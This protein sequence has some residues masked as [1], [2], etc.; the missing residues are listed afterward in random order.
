VGQVTNGLRA[1]LS[2]PR[3]YT[4]FQALMGGDSVRAQFVARNIRPEAGMNVLDI[5]CGP[6]GIL[7]YLPGVNYW[8]FDA[9]QDYIDAAHKKFGGRGHFECQIV[10]TQDLAALPSFDLVLAL[11][12]LHHLDDDSVH[13]LMRLS[14]EALR[15]GGRLVTIDPCLEPG[16]NPVARFL[17]R[18]DRGQNVRTRSE[19]EI[20]ARS[21]FA[22]CTVEVR[23]ASWIPYTHCIMECLR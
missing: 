18:R 14:L 19:Y 2:H 8:G 20:L 13:K 4:M 23:H 3:V 7:D 9:S 5:G 6:A 15:P 22:D 17:V 11:G 12:L 10:Q 16:Q 1:V 21:S